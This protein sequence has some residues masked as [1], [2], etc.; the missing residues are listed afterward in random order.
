MELPA[1]ES[2]LSASFTVKR[3]FV[4][5][6]DSYNTVVGMIRPC[7]QD[8]LHVLDNYDQVGCVDSSALSKYSECEVIVLPHMDKLP[9]LKQ[10][11]LAKWLLHLK[12]EYPNII[13]VATLKPV[14]EDAAAAG[15]SR[16]P[17]SGYL[18][19]KFWFATAEPTKAVSKETL[20]L[21][22][23]QDCHRI[24]IHSSIR[25]YVLDIVVFLRMH[26]LANQSLSG[27]ASTKSLDDILQLTQWLVAT[28]SGSASSKPRTFANPDV[29]QQACLWYFPM[30]MELI[31]DPQNDTSVMYGSE[32]RFVE[33]LIVGLREFTRRAGTGNPL[34]MET[35]VVKDVLN[36]VVPA[37]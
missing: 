6:T 23:P 11:R 36:K 16:F 33:E 21:T 31:K 9:P 18:K 12:R 32:P 19:S 26:R 28:G 4:C 30:H 2:G 20:L 8:A 7:F 25:R 27:G 34:V 3:N 29:V 17:L 37:L 10:N 24:T 1:F 15:G 13:C 22:S 35:L 14:L 5:F